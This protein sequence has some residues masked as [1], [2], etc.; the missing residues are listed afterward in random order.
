M[1]WT[2]LTHKFQVLNV[3]IASTRNDNNFVILKI[4]KPPTVQLTKD[5]MECR[6]LKKAISFARGSDQSEEY[7]IYH[8]YKHCF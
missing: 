5:D 7:N 3:E 8:I 1:C 6:L 4:C 2:C